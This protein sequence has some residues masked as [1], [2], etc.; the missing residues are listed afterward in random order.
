MRRRRYLKVA[1]LVGSVSLAGCSSEPEG[2]N[3]Q[4]SPTE[5][6]TPE[7]AT[8][9]TE[10]DTPTEE[11]ETEETTEEETESAP[12]EFEIVEVNHPDS[13]SV[14][15]GHT[16]SITVENTGGQTGTFEKLLEVSFEGESEWENVGY[17]RI[18][19]VE[20]GETETWESDPISFE[21]PATIQYRLGDREWS[22]AIEI[23]APDP[24]NF[25]GSGEEVREGVSIQGGL[26]VV[27]AT[28]SGESNF[29]VQLAGG[30]YDIL[31]VNVIGSYDGESAELVEEGEYIM[32][33]TADGSWE[34]TVRQPRSGDGEALPVSYS[35]NG[36]SVVGPVRFDGTGVARGTHDGESNFQVTIYPMTGSFGE[37]VFNEIG[38]FEGETTY[39]VNGIGWIEVVAD[40]NW[41]IELE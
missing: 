22:Y 28:H 5:T 11:T 8:Q 23:E 17:I 32:D 27:E 26:T 7:T 1:G 29:Q 20:P 10:T 30:E 36:Q 9:Q 3:D 13:V 40:G 25:A 16:F 38:T 6:A 33:I 31:F 21:S 15:E 18:E 4:S 19:D 14:N 12:A 2:G 37:L 41:N 39:S 24:Q 34:I 35:G